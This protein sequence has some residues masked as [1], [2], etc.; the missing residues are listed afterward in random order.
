MDSPSLKVVPRVT[1]SP[2]TRDRLMEVGAEA[3]R[4]D[5]ARPLPDVQPAEVAKRAGVKK[6]ALYQ[7]WDS[8]DDYRRDLI[9]ELLR[10]SELPGAD[11]V[12]SMV[13]DCIESRQ[14]PNQLS[15]TA[16]SDLFDSFAES[17]ACRWIIAG[18]PH[19]DDERIAAAIA[20]LLADCAHRVE[21]P[22]R[23]LLAMQG[24]APRP[25]ITMAQIAQ[26]VV[27]MFLG[28]AVRAQVNRA[29]VTKLVE[30][31]GEQWP[32]V[33]LGANALVSRCSEPIDGNS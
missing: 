15:K 29:G 7:H 9:L 31:D 28:L 24:R 27:S 8:F 14:D 3:V 19:R 12:I 23:L 11:I 22:L 32:L 18:Y 17:S 1:G 16:F 4:R 26:M 6:G 21:Q 5:G 2:T 10:D 33:A 25:K 13:I 20:E 30:F